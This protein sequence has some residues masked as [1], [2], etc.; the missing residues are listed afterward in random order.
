MRL[1]PKSFVHSAIRL[2]LRQ[3][4]RVD[5]T[6]SCSANNFLGRLPAS[7]VSVFSTGSEH[8]KDGDGGATQEPL[9]R[10]LTI[11]PS[12][13]GSR[14][15]EAS[16]GKPSAR[17]ISKDVPRLKALSRDRL[18]GGPNGPIRTPVPDERGCRPTPLAKPSGHEGGQWARPS[19]VFVPDAVTVRQLANLLGK[20]SLFVSALFLIGVHMTGLEVCL[21]RPLGPASC[22]G[23]TSLY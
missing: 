4:K 3:A 16:P 22:V 21:L 6:L 8:L 13:R 15:Q 10:W 18:A 17:P 20:N 12:A 9:H 5:H 11:K 2:Y 19:E 7:F 1:N 23:S 14:R